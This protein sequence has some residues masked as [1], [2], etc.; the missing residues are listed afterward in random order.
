MINSRQLNSSRTSMAYHTVFHDPGKDALFAEQLFTYRVI[1]DVI[2]IIF[3]RTSQ[4]SFH[5]PSFLS[6]KH[7]VLNISGQEQQ[8]IFSY[9]SILSPHPPHT[10]K[11]K[12]PLDF[13]EV[14]QKNQE[15][16][17][18]ILLC[19]RSRL[20]ELE[21]DH[22]VFNALSITL[23][24]Y[25]NSSNCNSILTS[26]SKMWCIPRKFFRLLILVPTGTYKHVSLFVDTRVYTC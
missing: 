18:I 1:A 26:L 20:T 23:E 15:P 8:H 7:I 25:C 13:F 21:T 12:S 14:F 10:V 9:C 17:N 6:S 16:V 2:S 19:Y 24:K 5:V 11:N 4:G 22:S 3:N